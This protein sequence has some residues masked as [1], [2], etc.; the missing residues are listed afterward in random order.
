M[1][2]FTFL[3]PGGYRFT[4][5]RLR[6]LLL[7]ALFSVTLLP[8]IAQTAPPPVEIRLQP[9]ETAVR[10]VTVT[11]PGNASVN[12]QTA[13][14]ETTASLARRT[15]GPTSLDGLN[16]VFSTGFEDYTVGD[17]GSQKGWDDLSPN[18]GNTIPVIASVSTEN[19][20]NGEK[21]LDFATGETSSDNYYSVSPQIEP[22]QTSAI[23][24][25]VFNYELTQLGGS[26]SFFTYQR[27]DTNFTNSIP[28]FNAG[29]LLSSGGKISYFNFNGTNSTVRNFTPFGDGLETGYVEVTFVLNRI[30]STYDL[31]VDG[32][33]VA[34]NILISN[35]VLDG[36]TVSQS[37]GTPV[38]NPTE[39]S[40]FL[41]DL[42]IVE[43]DASTPSW[44]STPTTSGTLP[45][46]GERTLDVTVNTQGLA[47]GTYEAEVQVLD[48]AFG[49]VSTVPVTLIIEEPPLNPVVEKLNLTSMCS[50]DPE[51]ELRWRIRNPNDFAVEV[52]WQLY[53]STQ[54]ATVMAAPGDSFFFTQTESGANTTIIRWKNEE[55]QTKQKIKASGK[56]PCQPPVVEPSLTVFPNP[57]GDAFTV[58]I[59]G[60]QGPGKLFIW[61][62]GYRSVL[63]GEVDPSARVTSGSKLT[64]DANKLG[65][66]SG[67]T[68][69][70]LLEMPTADGKIES[71]TQR[72]VK[73]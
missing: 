24:S 13:L 22:E 61:D 64:F 48:E 20:L 71:I 62:Q 31:Y 54:A 47:P 5:Q 35:G 8:A 41:D 18:I 53:G 45:A 6:A 29:I 33:R 58:K 21:H 25:V 63:A 17:L 43:G 9:G 51:T 34:E 65:L 69:I 30:T 1:K 73:E 12:F 55:G 2:N 4:Y 28:R 59:E 26:Y 16:I 37:G 52:D 50:D 11:N 67:K 7:L 23:R 40:L 72:I 57:V 15:V 44:I 70:I 49:T 38:L 36:L 19:P 56:A 14:K 10:Q 3:A 42:T 60:G 32:Q 68:Y 39:P 66:K 27:K 46:Q